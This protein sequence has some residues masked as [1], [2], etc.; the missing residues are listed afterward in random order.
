MKKCPAVVKLSGDC[1][2][3]ESR[4]GW[5]GMKFLFLNLKVWFV[6][7]CRGGGGL[8]VGIVDIYFD[9]MMENLIGFRGQ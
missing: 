2:W 7:R 9:E 4:R 6:K 8:L 1:Y 5:E 3:G